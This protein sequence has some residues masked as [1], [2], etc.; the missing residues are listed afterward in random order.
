MRAWH[1]V[2]RRVR[3]QQHDQAASN[4]LSSLLILS[5][6][7]PPTRVSVGVYFNTTIGVYATMC[8]ERIVQ[9]DDWSVLYHVHYPE[10][11]YPS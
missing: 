8:S 2:K 11:H 5:Y 4:N 9:H 1:C 3:S 6:A 7:H 10:V